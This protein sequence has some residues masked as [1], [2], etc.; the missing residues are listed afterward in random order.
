LPNLTGVGQEYEK[1]DSAEIVLDGTESLE[2]NVE[3]LLSRIAG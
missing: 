1:P 3:S 2:V